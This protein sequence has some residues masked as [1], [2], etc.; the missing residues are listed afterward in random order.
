MEKKEFGSHISRRMN[1]NLE[2]VFNSILEMGGLVES[3]LENALIALTNA[4]KNRADEVLLLDKR[5]NL[6]EL[7]IEKLC[8][9]ILVRQQP[10]AS[11]LRLTIAAI[12][13]A[14]DLERMGDEIM[15][16]AKMVKIFIK[17]GETPA[18][19][20]P[21]YS[22]LLDISNRSLKILHSSLD[23]FAR[24]TVN[25][26]L[27]V[28]DEEETI[29]QL[30]AEAYKDIIQGFKSTPNRADCIA[31]MLLSLRAVERVSDHVINIIENVVYLINGKDIRV[32]DNDSM[33]KLMQKMEKIEQE[34]G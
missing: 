25:D 30:Y 17:K 10:T 22:N 5:V 4:D 16:I 32:M 6:A 8:T 1:K 28:I 27:S 24:L 15:K 11:D 29:N 19:D 20:F 9:N 3:Q 18:N 34:Q 21:G 31:Q 26:I 7:E 23:C 13:I 14:I 33:V 2:E 12:R